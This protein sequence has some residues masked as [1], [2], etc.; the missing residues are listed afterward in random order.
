MTETQCGIGADGALS[1][2]EFADL[3]CIVCID[4][5][6]CLGPKVGLAGHVRK[7]ALGAEEGSSPGHERAI[8][9]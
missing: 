4:Q 7:R 8:A 1:M 6:A 3:T 5:K 9:L 2:H